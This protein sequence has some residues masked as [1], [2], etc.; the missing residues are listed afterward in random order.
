MAE[1]QFVPEYPGGGGQVA[2]E[3][4]AQGPL[5]GVP[6]PSSS[7]PS[8]PQQDERGTLYSRQG[9]QQS[10]ARGEAGG[11]PRRTGSPAFAG[12]DNLFYWT[13]AR[14]RQIIDATFSRP[15][16]RASARTSRF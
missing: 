7:T 15:M 2:V 3:N 10:Q 14:R 8:V 16:M 1:G 13:T 11:E 6:S 12:D 9:R 5:S 4:F